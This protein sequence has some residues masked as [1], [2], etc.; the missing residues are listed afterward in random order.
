MNSTPVNTEKRDKTNTETSLAT[1]TPVPCPE[2]DGY[3]KSTGEETIC[4]DCGLVLSEYRIDHGPEWRSL[5][6]NTTNPKRTGAPL[7]RSRHDRGL[8]TEIGRSIR[9]TGRKQ[10]QFA[11]LRRQHNRA[12]ISTKRE[13][14]QV[15]A[16]TEIRRLTGA[17]SLPEQIRDDACSLFRSAQS[18]DLLRGRSL[19]GFAAACVYAACR[20]ADVARTAEEITEIAKA[21]PAEQ[22]AAYTALNRELGLPIGPINPA[23]Y[24]PRFASELELPSDIE[25]CARE[26]VS[27]ITA[28]EIGAGRNPSG[29]AAACLYTAAR[30]IGFEL[31]QQT[32]ANI[33]DVTPVTLR[34]TYHDLRE[35]TPLSTE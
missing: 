13:R 11:R 10:R 35:L 26:Y 25:R 27:M 18:E 16:F 1:D 4:G 3:P 9:L 20:V 5:A 14:N 19:E 34:A 31:T 21:T 23:Q 6:D 12:R 22:R 17:F 28:Q 32:A 33:A 15:Y 2:C 8:S 29:V 24:L 30:D 7:T